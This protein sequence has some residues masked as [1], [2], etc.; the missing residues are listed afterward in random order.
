VR[1]TKGEVEEAVESGHLQLGLLRDN[2]SQ[3]AVQPFAAGTAKGRGPDDSPS[4]SSAWR[5]VRL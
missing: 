1:L 3:Q 2:G 4:L 5:R